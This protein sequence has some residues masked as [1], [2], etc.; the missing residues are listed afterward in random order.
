MVQPHNWLASVVDTHDRLQS[1]SLAFVHRDAAVEAERKLP[2][3]GSLL[4]GQFELHHQ[5]IHLH[6]AEELGEQPLRFEAN[7]DGLF[8]HPEGGVSLRIINKQ[9]LSACLKQGHHLA[10]KVVLGSS[11]VIGEHYVLVVEDAVQP[12]RILAAFDS[13]F[14]PIF[15]SLSSAASLRLS[16]LASP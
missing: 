13:A 5:C 3:S 2:K 10:V 9:K 11:C 16:N 12:P 8:L 4:N 1:L 14:R 7:F 15:Q 6:S